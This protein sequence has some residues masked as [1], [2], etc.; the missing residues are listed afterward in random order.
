[1]S[2]FLGAKALYEPDWGVELVLLTFVW[3]ADMEDGFW[4]GAE[5]VIG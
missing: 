1:V 5:L 3:K 2:E 4:D